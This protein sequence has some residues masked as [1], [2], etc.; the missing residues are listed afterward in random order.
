MHCVTDD[1]DSRIVGPLRH[2]RGSR[3]SDL[4]ECC[5]GLGHLVKEWF[6]PRSPVGRERFCELGCFLSDDAKV[7]S[8]RVDTKIAKV[9]PST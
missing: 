6:Q 5:F 4:P 1:G 7:V 9:R 8:G 3:A 2:P